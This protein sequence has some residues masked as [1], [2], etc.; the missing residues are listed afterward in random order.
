MR[1]IVPDTFRNEGRDVLRLRSVRLAS[2]KCWWRRAV[3]LAFVSCAPP[4]LVSLSDTSS[5]MAATFACSILSV[6]LLGGGIALEALLPFPAPR[7]GDGH[8]L[9]GHEVVTLVV[10]DLR[11]LSVMAFLKEINGTIQ[12]G[13]MFHPTRG[14]CPMSLQK[15]M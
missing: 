14:F 11:L 15:I 2:G 12:V 10:V 1:G 7:E 4:P 6:A 5:V 3:P 8:S 9:H 13:L